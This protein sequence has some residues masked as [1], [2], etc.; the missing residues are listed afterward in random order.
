LEAN[1]LDASVKQ[2]INLEVA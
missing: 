2:A 1:D